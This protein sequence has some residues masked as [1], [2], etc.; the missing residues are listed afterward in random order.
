M[1]DKDIAWLHIRSQS[2]YHDEAEIIGTKAGLEAAL[3]AIAAALANR[4]GNA[5]VFANDGEGYRL[6]VRCSNRVRDLGQPF[7]VDE[8]ARD[9]AVAERK[10]IVSHYKLLRKQ[11]A[12]AVD[13]LRWCR[14][15]GNPHLPP[16]KGQ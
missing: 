9:L 12:E 13:A 11:D 2:T 7:Y 6:S 1:T 14:A 5:S 15:N 3:K 16:S 10:Q 8:I 4:D